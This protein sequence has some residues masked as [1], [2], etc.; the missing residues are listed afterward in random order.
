MKIYPPELPYLHGTLTLLW[1][2]MK[3]IQILITYEDYNRRIKNWNSLSKSMNQ[4]CGETKVIWWLNGA[5]SS[6]RKLSQKT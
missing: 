4:D 3:S 6:E 5:E 2:L 1:N